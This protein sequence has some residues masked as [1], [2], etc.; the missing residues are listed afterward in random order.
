MART[1]TT[2]T[3]AAAKPV[4]ES[5]GAKAERIER[6]THRAETQVPQQPA[7]RMRLL[8]GKERKAD[9]TEN[10]KRIYSPSGKGNSL[11]KKM[12]CHDRFK[13]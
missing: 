11:A 13:L 10:T 8:E 6:A 9:E 5:A 3:A 7:S 12:V 2:G 4:R 1:V